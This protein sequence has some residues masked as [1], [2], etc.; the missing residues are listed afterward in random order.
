MELVVIVAVFSRGQTVTNKYRFLA[1][2]GGYA[3]VETQC[4][5]IYNSRTE[6]PQCVVC[7]NF[8]IRYNP[9]YS[10]CLLIMKP[11]LQ[12]SVVGFK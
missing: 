8:M 11:G 12:N 5:I 7:V 3:W 6:K 9:L 10:L 2:R 4:T 1:R